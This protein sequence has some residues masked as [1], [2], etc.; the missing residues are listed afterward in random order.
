MSQAGTLPIAPRL[1]G[2]AM[3]LEYDDIPATVLG[4][5]RLGLIDWF[6]VT[7][8]G[9][10]DPEADPLAAATGRQEGEVALVGRPLRAPLHDAVLFNGTASHLFDFDDTN[11]A[12]PGHPS[13]PVLAPVLA[14]AETAG[15]SG[16]EVVT[17]YV[18]GS[19][20]LCRLGVG[21]APEHYE[22]GFHA[23]ATLGTFGGAIGAARLLGLDEGRATSAIGIA[24]IRAAGLKGVFGTI[25]KPLQTGMGAAAGLDAAR[26]AAA[27]VVMADD[28][29]E[30]EQGFAA[31]HGGKFD[32]A[33]AL[34]EPPDGWWMLSNRFKMHAACGLL[35]ATIEA[36][37]ELAER[38]GVGP[39][40][41]A[42]VALQMD[43][44]ARKVCHVEWARTG[45][46]LKFCPRFAAAMALAGR[47]TAA[48]AAYSDETA[49]DSE[50]NALA[51]RVNVEF[52]PTG[53]TM[54]AVMRIR[55]ASGA[56]YDQ[57]YDADL[58]QGE[59]A[60]VRQRVL[61]KYHQLV[62]PVLGAGRAARLAA[63]LEAI[64]DA[65]DLSAIL[66]LA[67]P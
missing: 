16:R 21:F 67:R 9:A 65:P 34:A 33:A 6:A 42:E 58:P 10:A 17:A 57:E 30:C 37:L 61:A 22:A 62:D 60:K 24:A 1:A 13:V 49:A 39:G 3:A 7:V 46:E 35:Q 25:G 2:A 8:A 53:R 29:I 43:Q 26:L 32:A 44:Q 11:T 36:G 40:E 4:V 52:R 27:G 20:A 55:T 15:A 14:L 12:V 47:D 64:D 48:L 45:T 28:V 38:A 41:I 51:A 56:S 18:A 31:T 19:E 5:A 63:A 23:S 66:A 59:Y 50:L 54:R